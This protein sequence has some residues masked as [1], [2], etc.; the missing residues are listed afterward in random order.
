MVVLQFKQ[1]EKDSFQVTL[2][3][4]FHEFARRACVHSTSKQFQSLDGNSTMS[5]DKKERVRQP[6]L[7]IPLYAQLT[8]YQQP[9]RNRRHSD[10][11]DR[12]AHFR[13]HDQIDVSREIARTGGGPCA[14]VQL[15]LAS[16]SRSYA[17]QYC[18]D[19]TNGRRVI[20][21]TLKPLSR[22]DFGRLGMKM[23]LRIIIRSSAVVSK[24]QHSNTIL[25]EVIVPEAVW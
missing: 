15:D 5:S 3:M 6:I 21:D 23:D 14:V 16:A 2:A 11:V 18:C 20:K 1:R 19:R 17:G 13:S 25:H 22:L 10:V 4:L 12:C 9:T 8:C 24:S 7:L